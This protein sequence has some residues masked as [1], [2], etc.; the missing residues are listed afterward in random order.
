MRKTIISP[1][2][3]PEG[4]SEV[5]C[6]DVASMARVEVSSECPDHPIEA[7]LVDGYESGW[8]AATSGEQTIR[9]I[10]DSPVTV[11]N[12]LLVI[13]ELDQPRT[14]EFVFSWKKYGDDS[15]R[16]I[17]RQQFNFTPPNTTHQIEK[18][19]VNLD[20][21]ESLELKINPDINRIDACAKLTKLSLG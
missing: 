8:R 7:A 20:S 5:A 13:D 2:V 12:I 1:T 3:I 4:E 9:L 19:Q 21:L 14:Q 10:F 11:N 17:V 6:F 15:V 16:E 18:Y